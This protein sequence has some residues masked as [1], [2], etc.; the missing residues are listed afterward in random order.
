MG[1]L[2]WVGTAATAAGIGG[3]FWC[4]WQVTRAKR[5][6]LDDAA[7]RARLQRIVVLNLA[8]LGVSALGLALVIAGIVLG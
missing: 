2:I 5:A 1:G 6:G 8:A 7:L 4:I 3:L